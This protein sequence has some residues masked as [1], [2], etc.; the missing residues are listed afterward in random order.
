MQILQIREVVYTH[1]V[2]QVAHC[3][4]P[5]AVGYEM[6]FSEGV[7]SSGQ[8][9]RKSEVVLLV[10]A[11]SDLPQVPR[12]VH[13]LLLVLLVAVLGAV[14]SLDKVGPVVS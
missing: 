8:A 12:L 6:C 1:E 14:D 7:P 4:R 10:V 2:L 9:V 11:A 3:L 5:L 13:F